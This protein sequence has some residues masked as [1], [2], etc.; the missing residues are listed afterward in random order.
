M[1][2]ITLIT[3]CVLVGTTSAVYVDTGNPYHTG[4][5]ETRWF[6]VTETFDDSPLHS[7][8]YYPAKAGDYAVYFFVPG[9][10]GVIPG[11]VYSD[12]LRNVSSHGF[13]VIGSDYI[14]PNKGA[15]GSDRSRRELGSI[16]DSFYK[17][18]IWL[19]AKL[20]GLI[21][22]LYP[23]VTANWDYLAIGGH[24]AGG[25]TVLKIAE[26]N[27][28]LAKVALFLE[29]MSFALSGPVG[30]RLPS[31]MYGT[32]LSEKHKKFFPPCVVPGLSYRHFYNNWMT[33]KVMVEVE[34]Y[35]HC[36]ILDMVAWDA[37]H[38]LGIC[39]T[40]NNTGDY[41][42]IYHRFIQ[43]IS[44]A[45]MVSQMLGHNASIAWVINTTLVPVTYQDLR[46]NFTM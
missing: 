19:Q 20:Q 3:L 33:P 5:L 17:Q 4:P 38:D 1:A 21:H 9:L 36:D 25:D 31:L 27:T 18:L 16:V 28:S 10:Y 14:K 2:R 34:N 45:F 15:T 8:V 41:L 46:Y 43:G 12:Y 35:G 32:Q 6:W 22:N 13:I 40:R 23:G 24:S 42:T 37:C 39:A 7:I 29:P 11:E 44:S 30:F 26:K